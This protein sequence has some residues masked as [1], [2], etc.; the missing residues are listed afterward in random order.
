MIAIPLSI[1]S[2]NRAI[3]MAAAEPAARLAAWYV[4]REHSVSAAMW[5]PS[6]ADGRDEQACESTVLWLVSDCLEGTCGGKGV[7]AAREAARIPWTN[8]RL[9]TL[10][11]ST[12]VA[13]LAGIKTHFAI[14]PAVS[15]LVST[16]FRRSGLKKCEDNG[17][18]SECFSRS[19][20]ATA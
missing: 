18:A 10:N 7:W 6:P 17:F 1:M 11:N 8:S 15:S 3:A 19:L 5:K 2:L 20:M 14:K 4:C 16:A 9:W 13:S 12:S